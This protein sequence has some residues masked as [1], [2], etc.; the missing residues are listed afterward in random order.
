MFKTFVIQDV[1]SGKYWVGGNWSS[2]PNDHERM[3][4]YRWTEDIWKAMSF[5]KK[6]HALEY[7]SGRDS[8]D[9]KVVTIVMLFV[10]SKEEK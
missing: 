7:I 1:V 2:D 8:F 6:R 3:L 4:S 5:D 9:G 10:N